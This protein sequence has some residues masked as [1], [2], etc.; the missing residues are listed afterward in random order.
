VDPRIAAALDQMARCLHQPVTVGD[1]AVAVNLSTSRF[2]HLFRAEIGE[3]PL[4]YLLRLRMIHAR[5]LLEESPLAVKDVMLSVGITDASHFAREFRKCHGV[6]ARE[7]RR[8]AAKQPDP[9]PPKS[10]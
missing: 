6:T 10:G 1:F 4:R 8:R 2:A 9:Y 7:L 3:S 5:I